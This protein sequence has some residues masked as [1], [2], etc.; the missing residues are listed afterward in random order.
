[1]GNEGE[2]SVKQELRKLC[3]KVEKCIR[4]IK[5]FESRSRHA[6]LEPELPRVLLARAVTWTTEPSE[7]DVRRR[8]STNTHDQIEQTS[9]VIGTWH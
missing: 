2:E 8:Q 6:E 4:A 1:M 9:V 5:S 3:F 7:Q